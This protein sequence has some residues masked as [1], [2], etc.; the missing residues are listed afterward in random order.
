M[1]TVSLANTPP[2]HASYLVEEPW[3]P[4]FWAECATV[5]QA[6]LAEKRLLKDSFTM[7]EWLNL[8]AVT[9]SGE[10]LRDDLLH[11]IIRYTLCTP[12]I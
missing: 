2:N 11:Y 6:L 4:V 10:F 1:Q 8:R 7:L 3:K 12:G 9:I 5:I